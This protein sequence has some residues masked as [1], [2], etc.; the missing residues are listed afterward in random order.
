[1]KKSNVKYKVEYEIELRRNPHKGLYIALEGIDGAGKT[2]QIGLLENYL[3]NHHKRFV[4]TAEPRKAGSPVGELIHEI[5]K[6]K[7]KIPP[8]AN[9]FLFTADRVINHLEVI[10]PALK[11]G[12]VVLSHRCLWSNL[13]YGMLDKE[14]TDYDSADARII[15]AAHGLLSLYHQFIIPDIAFYL[16]ISPETAMERIAHMHREHEIYEK[17]EKLEKIAKGYEWE[18]KRFPDEFVVI[19][20]EKSEEKVFDQIKKHVDRALT[21]TK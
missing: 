18:V 19:D 16:R 13:P 17:R 12:D 6:G 10:E 8:L 9:Q 11:R 3:R 21:E 14:E 4:E 1:M 20:G 5:L 7:I 15:N 2:T